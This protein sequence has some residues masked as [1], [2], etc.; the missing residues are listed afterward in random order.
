MAEEISWDEAVEDKGF[1]SFEADKQKVITITNWKLQKRAADAKVG[2]GEIEFDADVI[3]EDGKTVKERRLNTTSK[4]F[5]KKL[6]PILEGKKP[7]DKVTLS[8]MKVGEK[9]DTQ[10]SI[11][12]QKEET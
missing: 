2:A 12:E 9:F 4:R 6:R 5:K 3:K 10:Y 11:V 7:E 1:I 8:V